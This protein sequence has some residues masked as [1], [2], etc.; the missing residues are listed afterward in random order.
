MVYFV[1][2]QL[3]QD[4]NKLILSQLAIWLCINQSSTYMYK[5]TQGRVCRAAGALT[6]CRTVWLFSGGQNRPYHQTK[7]PGPTSGPGQPELPLVQYWLRHSKDQARSPGLMQEAFTC[8]TSEF[9]A[10]WWWNWWSREDV[11]LH[12]C[13]G[14]GN[15]HPCSA[16]SE[17]GH[18][19]PPPAQI[20]WGNA[21]E[22]RSL[23]ATST[24]QGREEGGRLYWYTG[25]DPQLDKTVDCSR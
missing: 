17:E 3:L 11:R 13:Q 9:L 10:G 23:H 18:P 16:P 1:I 12:N 25:R 5:P 4:F 14:G 15:V 22:V 6:D 7:Q 21:T 19:R 2:L 20:L 24:V 8:R